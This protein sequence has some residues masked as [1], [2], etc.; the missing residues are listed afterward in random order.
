VGKPRLAVVIAQLRAQGLGAV[1]E[2]RQCF[3]SLV[4]ARQT[5]TEQ[6]LSRAV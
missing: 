3:R 6:A 4:L 5:L 1:A 2:Q